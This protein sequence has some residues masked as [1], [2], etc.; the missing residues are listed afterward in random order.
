[1]KYK[2]LWIEDGA[3]ADLSSF[4]GPLYVSG[5]FHIV[6]A[7]NASDAVN[8]IVNENFDAVIIDIRIPPGE[9]KEWLD[10][11]S[12]LGEDKVQARLGVHLLYSLLLPENSKVKIA[13]I[14]EWV[15]P[16]IIGVFSI[17]SIT[18]LKHDLD[19]LGIKTYVQKN[20]TT[21]QLELLN[22]ARSL[23]KY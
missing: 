5:R 3:L 16:S 12:E 22:M 21:S 15:A 4:L 8:F 6:I 7:F 23:V 17:E 10:I 14:P 19:A 13:Y 9:K 18:Q 11:Y 2:L 1:M 20:A